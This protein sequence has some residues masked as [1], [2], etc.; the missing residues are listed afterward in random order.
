[1]DNNLTAIIKNYIRQAGPMDVGTYMEYCLTHPEF[2]YYIT[3]SPFGT[4]GDFV[5]AP[6]VSQLFGEMIGIFFQQKFIEM[7]EPEHIHIV[8]CGAG[9][10]ALM[11]DILRVIT[12]YINVSVHIV[13]VS[14]ALRDVQRATIARDDITFHSD[15]ETLPDGG[16]LFIVGN[17]F[18]DAIPI[19]QAICVDGKWHEHVIGIVDDQLSFVVGNILP[20]DHLPA[21]EKEKIYE[22]SPQRESIHRAL[23]ERIKAQGGLLLWVDYGFEA[24]SNAAS[25]QGIKDHKYKNVLEDCGVSDISSLVDFEALLRVTPDDL[26]VAGV[27]TQAK[28]LR[29][30]GIAIR[31]DVLCKQN[32]EQEK[33]I[34]SGYHRL[35][36]DD[37]MGS[38]FKVLAVSK[39]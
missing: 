37:Q 12:P 29:E 21:P 32:P 27:V 17:E 28:F 25:L 15:F 39:S 11:R 20:S 18:L 23:C 3:Q 2:G 35:M 13:E 38:L 1:V 5:T 34:L 33:D 4:K 10:G 19:R 31:Y 6:E 22:F 7:G 36:D 16:S 9:R 30:C 8:E 26:K 14:H 24:G